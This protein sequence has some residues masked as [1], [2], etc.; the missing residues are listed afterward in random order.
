MQCM[1]S[2]FP[3]VNKCPKG[4]KKVN[5]VLANMLNRILLDIMTYLLRI[6]NTPHRMNVVATNSHP[7][8]T[9][10]QNILQSDRR[11]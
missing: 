1:H 2:I 5:I 10:L 6:M 7:V 9:N 4:T 3:R 8:I 11:T